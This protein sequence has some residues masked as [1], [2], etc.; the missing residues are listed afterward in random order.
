MRASTLR[1]SNYKCFQDARVDLNGIN[2]VIGENSS[3]KTALLEALEL[4]VGA[5]RPRK[6]LK[7][8]FHNVHEPVVISIEFLELDP[9]EAKL[10]KSLVRNDRLLLSWKWD[11]TGGLRVHARNL[12][13]EEELLRP[14]TLA[15]KRSKKLRRHQAYEQL[16]GRRLADYLAQDSSADFI[17]GPDWENAAREFITANGNRIRW[18]EVEWEVPKALLASLPAFYQVPPFYDFDQILKTN[19]TFDPVSRGI[20]Q[21]LQEANDTLGEELR[22]AISDFVRRRSADRYEEVETIAEV[23]ADFQAIK[24]EPRMFIREEFEPPIINLTLEID[25]GIRSDL[26]QKGHG[27]RRL[28][29]YAQ[30]VATIRRQERDRVLAG[31][32]PRNFILG[33]EELEL[34]LHPLYQSII[35]EQLAQLVET[36]QYQVV[37]TSHSS[38][39]VDI[40]D[41]ESVIRVSRSA[42]NSQTF[43]IKYSAIADKVND[44]IEGSGATADSVRDRIGEVLD[45]F[46]CQSLFS[47]KVVLVEG[48]TELYVLP[49]LFN[50]IG[51]KFERAGVSIVP[52]GGKG[53]I[54]KFI[55]LMQ[56]FGIP[57]FTVFDFDRSTAAKDKASHSQS[58]RLARLLRVPDDISGVY[59]GTN[60]CVFEV[61]FES[62]MR[63]LYGDWV[64]LDAVAKQKIGV[65]Q[66]SG[67]SLRA[68]YIGGEIAK[69]LA[70]ND[71]SVAE[72]RSFLLS[73]STAI[74]Q[75]DA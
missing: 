30:L 9:R 51:Y 35:L 18:I 26:Q 42:N 48:N 64:K 37:F 59:V 44:L 21:A 52:V 60:A 2:C 27:L 7:S 58:E 24:I 32:P 17:S 74:S 19:D 67:K 6:L 14:W 11:V 68:R 75:C 40:F 38:N 34:Y 46:N 50:A 43:Q 72:M 12:Q 55:F 66:E 10:F 71:P 70:K 1:I 47:R 62:T 5:R 28:V 73:L 31:K 61:D 56:E 54:D 63:Q 53:N 36:G 33:V 29:L 15:N 8:C 41:L 65:K 23:V 3:G 22:S 25:D 13:P 69:L 49:M 57:C 39:M 4:A 45:V 20:S 16:Y